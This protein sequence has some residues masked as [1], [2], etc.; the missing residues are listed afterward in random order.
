MGV[1]QGRLDSSK[2]PSNKKDDKAAEDEIEKID[3]D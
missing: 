2:K 3:E 1:D